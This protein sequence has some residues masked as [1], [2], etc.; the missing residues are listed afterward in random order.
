MRRIPIAGPWITDLE[1]ESVA[2][3]ARYAWYERAH[4]FNFAFEKEFAAYV[5]RKHAV[6][7]PSCTAGLHL[8]LAAL[9]IG[10]GD[11]VIVPD[12]T[13]IA[14][15]APITYVGAEPVF[16]DISEETWCIDVKSFEENI[17]QRTKA[18][19]PVDLYGGMPDYDNLLEVAR[20]AGVHVIE[21]AAEAV[22]SECAG[23]KAGGF[24]IASVFS[25]HGSKTLTTGE[26]GMIVTDDDDLLQRIYFLRD[27]GRPP[28]DRE[29]FNTAVAFKYRMS[30]VQAALGVAQ[31]RRINELVAKKRQIFQWYATR[32]GNQFGV[33]LNSEPRGTRNSYW[34]TT[35]VLD[36][37]LGMS[38]SQLSAAL[39][40]HEIDS[41]P[42]FH[43]LSSLPAYADLRSKD[44]SV[45]NPIA[46]KVCPYGLNLPSAM[47]LTEGQVDFVCDSLR[48]I[49]NSHR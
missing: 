7:L 12:A 39:D 32:L 26:G 23:R 18:V 6:S 19:I 24:G 4:E 13:W 45:T 11:E 33:S 10:P 28:F 5:G 31:L 44:A 36:Q 8:T 43:P 41:R 21:D 46:Y 35:I 25:F 15:S 49:L 3:A 27:H 17:T 47:S 1:V 37:S 48:Q 38:K 2:E 42:F 16:A 14:T 34:M 29:F 22:G 40:E 9:G 20:A 30:S